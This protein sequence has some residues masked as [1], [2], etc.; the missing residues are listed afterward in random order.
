MLSDINESDNNKLIVRNSILITVYN[1]FEE[2]QKCLDAIHACKYQE[3]Y[4]LV[5]VYHEEIPSTKLLLDL[6]EH[7]FLYLI[8]VNGIGR[9]ALLNMNSNRILG[10]NFCFEKL[11]SEMVIAVEDDVQLGYDALVF[12]EDIILRYSKN[13]S[14]RGVNLGSRMPRSGDLF[15]SYGKFRYGISGQGSAMT[16]D[17]WRKINNLNLLQG[18]SYKGFDSL[19]EDYFKTGFVI[20]PYAS[21]Y[22]DEGWRGT[23]ASPDPNHPYYID[24]QKS[25]VG[26]L[27]FA[28]QR[29]SCVRSK[30]SW[31]KDCIP[32][33]GVL[34]FYYWTKLIARKI[35]FLA[36]K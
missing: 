7:P 32:Y 3:N 21:R 27:P 9:T 5:I 25:F 12:S 14:F 11:G 26:S 29:L 36:G 33:Y 4:N 18:I 30:Y 20:S 22:L 1:R 6:V 34:N 28:Q 19:V 10:L 31:R 16:K 8:P 23:H 17:T 35:G 15:Y 2:F 13:S 24:L